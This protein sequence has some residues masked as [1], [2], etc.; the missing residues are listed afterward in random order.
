M[1]KPS[2]YWTKEKCKEEALK[3]K[4]KTDFKKYSL[5]AFSSAYKKHK[6]LDEICSHMPNVGNKYKRCIYVYEFSDNFAY[7]GLTFNLEQ[8]KVIHLKQGSVYK[9]IQKN[10]TYIIRQLTDYINVEEAQKLE[11][12]FLSN[13][14]K[15]GW[16][17]LNK[18]K[19]GSIGGNT[20]KWFKEKCKDEALKYLTRKE[21]CIKNSGA[22]RSS[23]HNNWLDEICS[24][25]AIK[26]YLE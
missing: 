13:Y 23:L 14:K 1:K 15:N 12:V 8:R 18:V 22:Y 17:I 6:C 26:K 24:H 10:N 16:S 21:F 19:T 4:S 20:K 25:Y 2:K 11:N 5:G 7:I 9:H 3:Y